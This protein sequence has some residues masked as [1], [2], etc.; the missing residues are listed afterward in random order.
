M[1]SII[2]YFN[3][4]NKLECSQIFIFLDFKIIW[5]LPYE[6]IIRGSNFVPSLLKNG[7]KSEWSSKSTP[8]SCDWSVSIVCRFVPLS[9]STLIQSKK[10][11]FVSRPLT[12]K[13][14]HEITS[15]LSERSWWDLIGES[16]CRSTNHFRFSWLKLHFFFIYK[17]YFYKFFTQ[18]FHI[19][20]N[21]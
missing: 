13:G 1:S 6:K 5:N 19:F 11:S 14:H 16:P 17:I 10:A 7:V 4:C 9:R 3:N 15:D 12:A 18:F 8:V 21:I 2:Q 20:T